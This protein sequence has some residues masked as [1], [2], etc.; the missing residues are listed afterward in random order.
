MPAAANSKPSN[1]MLDAATVPV[2]AWR[3]LLWKGSDKRR[4]AHAT[5]AAGKADGR[6]SS[7]RPRCPPTA[8]AMAC[9]PTRAYHAASFAEPRNRLGSWWRGA[10]VERPGCVLGTTEG[11]FPTVRGSRPTTPT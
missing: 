10:L 1:R 9:T 7:P 11:G 6:N 8:A 2:A 5:V 4:G 3:C